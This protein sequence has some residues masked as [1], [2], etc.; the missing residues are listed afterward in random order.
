MTEEL[1]PKKEVY[2]EMIASLTED[3]LTS[4]ASALAEHGVIGSVPEPLTTDGLTDMV[5][6]KDHVDL[7]L[8]IADSPDTDLVEKMMQ[9]SV[10]RGAVP[11]KD[12]SQPHIRPNGSRSSRRSAGTSG[13]PKIA[14]PA[15][16]DMRVIVK[17][18]P[19]PKKQGSKSFDRYALYQVGM[20]V[21]DFIRAGGSK[22][23]VQW[24]VGRSY[25][26]LAPPGTVIS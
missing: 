1:K 19:N 15:P 22:G 8:A 2:R 6:D 25:I 10:V 17:V 24:D 9:K 18:E 23:D 13:G 7:V 16:D 12:Q 20:T 21:S 26:E 4:F 14:A 11:G 5:A 3:Q